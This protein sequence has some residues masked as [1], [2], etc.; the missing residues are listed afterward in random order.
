MLERNQDTVEIIEAVGKS[1]SF[2]ADVL[3]D[4]VN[5]GDLPKLIQ[6]PGVISAVQAAIEGAEN[7]KLKDL[8]DPELRALYLEDFKGSLKLA[9]E[10]ATTEEDVEFFFG[11]ALALTGVVADISLKVKEIQARA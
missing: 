11:K 6:L 8:E 10:D 9:E 1:A 3:K 2:V 5:L 4:G 7:A